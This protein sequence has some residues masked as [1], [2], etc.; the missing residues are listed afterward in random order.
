[1]Q[2]ITWIVQ[3]NAE[4]VAY[5]LAIIAALT[6][7]VHGFQGFVMVL[8]KL[9]AITATK[10]DDAAIVRID[11]WLTSAE[12]GLAWLQKWIPT[13]SVNRAKS[14]LLETKRAEVRASMRPGARA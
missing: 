14:A 4:I 1:M 9:A 2:H 6:V 3:H 8:A 11:G 12:T 13:F 7:I 10:S 5:A